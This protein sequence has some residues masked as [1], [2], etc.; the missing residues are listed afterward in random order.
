MKF[1]II[2]IAC[3]QLKFNGELKTQSLYGIEGVVVVQR[4]LT[5]RVYTLGTKP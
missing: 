3:K 1:L 4:L 5:T 2:A